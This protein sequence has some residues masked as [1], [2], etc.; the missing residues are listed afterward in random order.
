MSS[1]AKGGTVAKGGP[2]WGGYER[3]PQ[4]ACPSCLGPNG[5]ATLNR[6]SR[7][8]CHRCGESKPS[9]NNSKGLGKGARL[10]EKTGAR[11]GLS[12]IGADGKR[13]LLGRGGAAGQR[14]ETQ[15]RGRSPAGGLQGSKS[16]QQQ[17][18][19]GARPR[20]YADATRGGGAEAATTTTTTTAPPTGVTKGKGGPTPGPKGKGGEGKTDGYTTVNYRAG[21]KAEGGRWPTSG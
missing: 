7:I 5:G 17:L 2:T 15:V 3:R 19:A 20:S 1:W 14:E 16:R 13:P 8:S 4:W 21:K 6:D 12:P 18:L 11:R 10:G 9:D